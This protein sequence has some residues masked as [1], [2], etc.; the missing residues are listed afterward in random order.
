MPPILLQ[1]GGGQGPA[2]TE[3]VASLPLG[4][5]CGGDPLERWG[6]RPGSHTALDGSPLI[7][8]VLQDS[9]KETVLV[10]R[11]LL[12]CSVGTRGPSW[13]YPIPILVL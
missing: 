9:G 10:G 1:D 3:V 8:I 5:L 6:E 13:E 4:A 7:S 12:G 11:D 2:Q